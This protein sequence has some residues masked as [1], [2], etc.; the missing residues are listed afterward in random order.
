MGGLFWAGS[1]EAQGSGGSEVDQYQL[2][3]YYTLLVRTIVIEF[4]CVADGLYMLN[5]QTVSSLNVRAKQDHGD[6]IS[7][8]A[9]QRAALHQVHGMVEHIEDRMEDVEATSQAKLDAISSKSDA[10][11]ASVMSLRNLAEQVM[12]FVGTF[13]R[14][15]RDLLYTIMQ[16]DWRTYQAVL[17]IQE[18]L[19]HSPSS[20][21]DSNIQFTNA[22]GEYRVHTF[23]SYSSPIE[24]DS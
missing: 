5:R 20:L 14:E 1:G 24:A 19:A 6:L 22:L 21:H 12:A 8:I 9:E 4:L 2:T 11:H 3:A 23:R 15:I 17:Q 10:T 16:A 13:P 18:R 7:K